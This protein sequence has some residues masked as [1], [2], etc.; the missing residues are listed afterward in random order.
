MRK[1]NRVIWT[2]S[3]FLIYSR[4]HKWI[5]VMLEKNNCV[6]NF[7]TCSKCGTVKLALRGH[8]PNCRQ[9]PTCGLFN[10]S[11]ISISGHC[12]NSGYLPKTSF[13]MTRFTYIGVSMYDKFYCTV[14][15]PCVTSFTVVIGYVLDVY[16]VNYSTI[17]RL[18]VRF[19]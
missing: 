13:R 12:V 9:N 8:P 1:E 3:T 10:F 15:C 18:N 2:K 7:V 11:F 6:G 19:S 16:A 17:P 4:T 5:C 14:C